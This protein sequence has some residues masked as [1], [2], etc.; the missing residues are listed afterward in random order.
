M[1]TVVKL[2]FKDENIDIKEQ[3]L[4]MEHFEGKSIVSKNSFIEAA[5]K[6]N[7]YRKIMPT[8]TSDKKKTDKIFKDIIQ[9]I[10]KSNAIEKSYEINNITFILLIEYKDFRFFK[11][12]LF[13]DALILP[14]N[15]QFH[16]VCPSCNLDFERELIINGDNANV[17]YSLIRGYCVCKSCGYIDSIESFIKE[18]SICEYF[19]QKNLK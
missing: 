19:I 10:N 8:S 3:L 16:F 4:F 1:L 13:N 5:I 15:N 18:Y 6:S 11:Y 7:L 14:R 2:I 9:T 12:F 17:E